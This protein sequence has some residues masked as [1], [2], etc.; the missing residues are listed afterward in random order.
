MQ[1]N[2][3][4]RSDPPNGSRRSAWRFLGTPAIQPGAIELSGAWTIS[5]LVRASAEVWGDLA[6]VE[7]D[8]AI[9]DGYRA[10]ARDLAAFARA[11]EQADDTTA[12]TAA[13]GA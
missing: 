8:P 2:S 7:D 12:G 6:A 1:R 10:M 13:P 4:A 3:M 9:A 5:A 11:L